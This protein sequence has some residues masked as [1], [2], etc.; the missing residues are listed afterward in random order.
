MS[1]FLNSV[2]TT[3]GKTIYSTDLLQLL[4]L[5]KSRAAPQVGLE[6]WKGPF[7]LCHSSAALAQNEGH[8]LNVGQVNL[9]LL[10]DH[11]TPEIMREKFF[12]APE[13]EIS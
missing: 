6:G 1:V 7:Q 10:V 9:V 11:T 3:G 13:F 2:L 4:L 8:V 5:L 12:S